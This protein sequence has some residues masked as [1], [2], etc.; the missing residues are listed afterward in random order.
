MRIQPFVSRFLSALFAG[1]L[2]LSLAVP[3][4]AQDA[5]ELTSNPGYVDLGQVQSWFNTPPN[6]EVNLKGTLLDLIAGSAEDG[7]SDFSTLVSQLKAI[8]VRGYPMR[9][10]SLEVIQQRLTDFSAQMEDSGWERVVYI[11]ED[12]E[13]VNI[14][15]RPNGDSIAGLTV[16]ATNPNDDESIFINIVGSISPSQ[17]GKIGRGLDIEELEN[18]PTDSQSNQQN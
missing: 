4:Q 18:V 12:D 16:L 9:N 15:V 14:Y 10:A 6:I 13:L 8:Q 1:L 2:A 17:I 3:T 5:S 7:D 11:R